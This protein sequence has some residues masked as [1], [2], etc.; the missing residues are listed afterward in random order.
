MALAERR[1]QRLVIVFLAIGAFGEGRFEALNLAA[2]GGCRLFFVIENN[3]YAQTTP[4]HCTCG[5]IPVRSGLWHSGRGEDTTD[6]LEI[7]D[8]AETGLTARAP[9]VGP[10]RTDPA[11]LSLSHRIPKG[12]PA[13][14]AGGQ[15]FRQRI[16][17]WCMARGW[18]RRRRVVEPRSSAKL[19]GIRASR[20]AQRPMRLPS[21]LAGTRH[22][23][24]PGLA[25]Q[26]LRGAGSLRRRVVLGEMCS[27]R[28]GASR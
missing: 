8:L 20:S 28:T 15:R 2:F 9:R 24:R 16:R 22:D 27:T 13:R 14:P 26:A 5:S 7:L 11:Y 21:R 19:T 18:S 1:R 23:Q 3:R 17:C 4:I 12:T 6:V 25:H 10:A